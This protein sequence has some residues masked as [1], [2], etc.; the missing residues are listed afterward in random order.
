[1]EILLA[2]IFGVGIGALAI[3]LLKKPQA[4]DTTV[5][6]AQLKALS[7]KLM[8][9]LNNTFRETSKDLRAQSQAD[10]QQR[11]ESIANLIKPIKE[12]LDKTEK[13]VRDIEKERK[14]D[15][16]A[17]KEHLEQ[18]TR[19]TQNLQGETNR[20]VQALK[21]PQ[22][23]GRW[24]ELTLHR[25][26]ELAGMVEHCDFEEQ[27]ATD[28]E[29]GRLRPDMTVY[30]PNE[31]RVV[32][33]AKTPLNAYLEAIEADNENERE[34]L[35]QRHAQ[36]VKDKVKDLAS[37]AYWQQFD[38]TLDFVVMFVPGEQFLA[39]ALE[40]DPGLQEAALSKRVIL[41]TPPTLV[42]LLRAIDYGWRQKSLEENAQKIQKLGEE[43]HTRAAT[44]T[45]H[46][47]RIGKNLDNSVK[48]YNDA[49]GSLERNLLPGA[50]KF[51]ELGIQNKKEIP[52]LKPVETATRTVAAP[53]KGEG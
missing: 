21:K 22:V 14:Q 10:L 2:L 30:L 15:Q 26:V 27:T 5:P 46:L 25:T 28:D 13:Q 34:A 39:P 7:A 42:A 11:Q 18:V 29:A 23:R 45:E 40:R 49:T 47:A 50:R 43:L 3:Y 31:R 4:P 33:D 37:K 41:A 8:E 20:L 36:Q 32:V 24:G 12:A 51:T 35:L 48:A 9:N 1:M 17:L 44:F 38:N 19:G 6:D 52:E 53:E 16:G